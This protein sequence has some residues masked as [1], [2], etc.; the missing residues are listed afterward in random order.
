MAQLKDQ[1]EDTRKNK[2]DCVSLLTVHKSKGLEQK[3]VIVMGLVEGI[4][5]HQRSYSLAEADVPVVPSGIAEERR[6]AYVAMT[7]AQQRLFLTSITR[8]RGADATPSRFIHE[9][10]LTP[11]EETGH[12][13]P[14]RIN[15]NGSVRK[16]EPQVTAPTLFDPA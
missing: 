3:V 15:R 6:L 8:Y 16:S 13:N 2:R 4:F 1:A 5:P 14:Y 12:L 11:T 9:A 10:G 7:R